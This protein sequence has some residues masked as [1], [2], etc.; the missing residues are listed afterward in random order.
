MMIAVNHH[1][2]AAFTHNDL[3]RGR[4]STP[5]RGGNRRADN[6]HFHF[7]LLGFRKHK[8]TQERQEC[9]KHK[10]MQPM[11]I[12]SS[13]GQKVAGATIAEPSPL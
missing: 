8:K 1:R 7:G 5:Q 11:N 10:Q 4:Q 3:R 13:L 2:I 9:F 12:R 6:Q